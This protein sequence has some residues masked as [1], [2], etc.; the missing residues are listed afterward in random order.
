MKMYDHV[1][2]LARL[3]CFRKPLHYQQPFHHQNGS[4]PFSAINISQR[5][6][7]RTI[8]PWTDFLCPFVDTVTRLKSARQLLEGRASSHELACPWGE[9]HPCNGIS[10]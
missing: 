5:I 1:Q 2:S 8:L 6:I 4:E 7:A 10:R 3:I 9:V